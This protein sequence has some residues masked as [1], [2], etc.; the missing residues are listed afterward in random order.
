MSALHVYRVGT[1]YWLAPNHAAVVD[2]LKRLGFL[3]YVL[4]GEEPF[5]ILEL[6]KVVKA[7]SR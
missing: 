5:V 1:A 7:L 4:A 2:E 3:D 6:G